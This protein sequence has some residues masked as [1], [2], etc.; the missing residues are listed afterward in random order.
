LKL[1]GRVKL[2]LEDI[3]AFGQISKFLKIARGFKILGLVNNTNFKRLELNT[4]I[5][6]P[7]VGLL[8]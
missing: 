7:K 4:K 3:K 8:S 1:Y 6:Q 2:G 5:D